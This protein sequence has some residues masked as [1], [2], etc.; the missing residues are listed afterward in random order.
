MRFP[1][2]E[3]SGV[4]VPGPA[5]PAVGTFLVAGLLVAPGCGIVRA[6]DANPVPVERLKAAADA[7]A[8]RLVETRRDLHQ[9]PELG[10]RE[11][12][13]GALLAE[14]LKALGL[15]VR[16][17]VA[18]TGVVAVLRGGRPGRVA[19]IRADID[20]LPIEERN[21]VPYRSVV[22]GVKHACGHDAHSTIVLGVAEVLAGMKREM[23]GTVVFIFQPAEEGPPEGEEGGAPLVI[24]EGGLANP[25]VEAIFGMHVD[26]L[27]DAGT[28]AWCE[29]AS[30]ASSDRFGVVIAGHRTHGAYPHTGLDP[31]P[32]AAD[33]INAFQALVAREIDA[34]SPKVLTIGSIA[35]GNRFNIIADQVALEGTIRALDE[36]VR[37]DLKKR[38]QRTVDGIA[39]AHGTTATL[40]WIGEGNAATNN[41]PVLMAAAR[42]ALER[43]CGREHV[44][45]IDAQM[46]SED[47]S[48]YEQVVPGIYLKLGVR[49]V[50]RGITAMIHTEEFDL[51]EAA[52]PFGVRAMAAVLWDF[53]AA[54]APKKA[55]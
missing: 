44:V 22:P 45:K 33:L 27:V 14:R 25:K 52:L 21:D 38:M 23:P 24:K 48:Y 36:S 11:T 15:E 3:L 47:F 42:P 32:V 1:T 9:H 5:R 50:S 46:G 55:A 43:A 54:P 28:I 16:Y 26:P 8:P 18:R 2:R 10:N 35:G 13:T 20:A 49:N 19:A 53:M 39:A 29:G 17:P 41:D 37:A 31:I 40:R 6:A 34:R 12:R 51:D 30:Y 7:L 4:A